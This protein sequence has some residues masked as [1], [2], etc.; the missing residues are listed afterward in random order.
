[1]PA[2]AETS[3]TTQAAAREPRED[4]SGKLAAAT[5][6]VLAGIHSRR[7]AE[8]PPVSTTQAS[9][10]PRASFADVEPPALNDLHLRHSRVLPS[11]EAILPLLPKGG[12]CA[13]IGTQSGYFARQLLAVLQPTQL[14][15]YA[16]DFGSFERAHFQSAIDAGVVRLHAGSAEEQWAGTAEGQFDVIYLRP[17]EWFARTVRSL[18]AAARMAKDDGYIL[19]TNYTAYSPLEGIKYGVSRAVNEFCHKGRFEIIYLALHPLGYQDVVIRRRGQT[20][21]NEHLGGAFLEA[22]D[23]NTYLPDVW[24]Y[25]IDKY[26]AKSVLDIGAG[27]GWSTKWFA[28]QGLLA[29]GVEGWPEALEKSQCRDRIVAHDYTWGPF[30]PAMSFDL[31]W[32]AEFVEHIEEEHVPNFMVSF[33]ACRHV[34]MTH[35]E[36]GQLGYHHV[37]CQNTDYWIEKMRQYGF[38][39][40]AAETAHLRAT[41]TQK[42]PWGRRT[43]TFF[44][45]REPGN[46]APAAGPAN[47]LPTTEEALS[48]KEKAKRAADKL[49]GPGAKLVAPPPIVPA[50]V[51]VRNGRISSAGV[52]AASRAAPTA[53]TAADP[54]SRADGVTAPPDGDHP[55]DRARS[56][57]SQSRTTTPGPDGGVCAEI[58]PGDE[59]FTGDRAHYFGVGESASRCI[60]AALEAARK[61]GREIKSILDMP[62][63]HGRV[64]RYLKA[65]FPHAPLTACD[66]NRGAV[67]FCARTFDAAPVYSDSDVNRIP[68]REKFDLI[69]CGSLLTHLREEPCAAL[70]RWFDAHLN[71]GAILIFTLHGRWVERSLATGR[72]KYSLSDERVGALL[73][74]YCH[75]GFGYADYPGQTNYGISVCS[76]AYV[77]GKLATLPDLKLVSYHE[78]GWDNHQD[79][80]CLQKQGPAE[81]LG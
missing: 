25:L 51:F 64:M 78:K 66:L 11:R 54:G 6:A 80:V 59:M 65:A 73:K 61:P 22:P 31:G 35:G 19:C 50:P 41:D 57:P 56:S 53:E 30:V 60:Q 32:C 24:T 4:L 58:A 70:V 40:D 81:L 43:L 33:Q 10:G 39:Y 28:E 36:I 55:I 74:D 29:L 49:F 13:E 2:T 21:E 37:N 3:Q 27:A 15:L 34:C 71:L 69:W 8:P 68:L 18:E 42:A 1:M 48:Q 45:R 77:V 9:A 12:V 44:K 72:Y 62:C 16:K 76:P 52:A 75:S 5:K 7:P 38:D 67:D 23:A 17:D 79:V 14:H 26:G 20:R 47:A 63:G 46:P